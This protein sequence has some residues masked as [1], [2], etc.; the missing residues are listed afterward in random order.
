MDFDKIQLEGVRLKYP[1]NHLPWSSAVP[2]HRLIGIDDTGFEQLWI[3]GKRLPDYTAQ[4]PGRYLSSFPYLS[5]FLSA[6]D[7]HL[8]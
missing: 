1:P 6:G 5:Y 3:V 7:L 8:E 4:H 2:N